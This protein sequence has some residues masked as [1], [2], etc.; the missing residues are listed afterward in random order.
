MKPKTIL[1]SRISS[2][3]KLNRMLRQENYADAKFF[4]IVDE[5]TFTHCLP[6]L[7]GS[8][9][10]LEQAEFF[11]VPVG[12]EAKSLE[13][14]AQLWGALLESG[15]DRNSVIVNL[16]GGCV[17]D[18]GGF[19]AAGFKRGIR[20]INVPTTLIGMVDAA[21]GGKTAVNLGNAKNQV[22]FF[23][24]PEAVCICPDFLDTLHD[25]DLESG[26]FEMAKTLLLSDDK[27]FDELITAV[28]GCK[29]L[30]LDVVKR[31]VPQCVDFK[32]CVVG[33]D[34]MEK[35]VRKILNLG[36]TFGHA[37]ESFLMDCGQ[38]LPH[39]A[40]VGIGLKCELYL[41]VKK[42]GMSEKVYDSLCRILQT[43]VTVPKFSLRDTE[44]IISYMHQDKKNREGLILCVLLQEIGVPVIDV[45][46]DENEVRDALLKASKF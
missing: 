12:E 18:L 29:S 16:G 21:I 42:I 20:Y 33:A 2:L 32:N 10:A 3:A 11:E 36:H 37:I 30:P 4:I 26:F 6:V 17:S 38:P 44:K 31:F 24:Q 1:P 35:S 39:G 25:V 9:S 23:H 45:A 19:V 28:E 15:A 8:V 46:L 22:G 13:V 40:A 27:A 5:N 7:V 14:A 43:F 34:L 41:S